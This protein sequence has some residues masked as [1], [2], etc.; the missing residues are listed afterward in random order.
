MRVVHSLNHC[1]RVINSVEKDILVNVTPLNVIYVSTPS[2][3]RHNKSRHSTGL[4]A[5]LTID[6]YNHVSCL[7][8]LLPDDVDPGSHPQHLRTM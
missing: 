5:K 4:L 1:L 3:N 6:L 7:L 2:K 8:K